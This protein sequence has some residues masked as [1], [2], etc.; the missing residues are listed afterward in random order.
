MAK[1]LPPRIK[2]ITGNRYGRWTVVGFSHTHNK[3]SYWN[4]RCDCGT[5]RTHQRSA[6]ISGSTYSCGCFRGELLTVRNTTHGRR[7]SPEYGSWR[8][9]KERCQNP[10]SSKFYLYGG[11][12]IA[13][14]DRWQRFDNFFADMGPKPTP[15]HTLE[16]IDTNGNYEPDNCRWIPGA[17]QAANRRNNHR[18]T[19]GEDTRTIAE[20]RR[21]FHISK[22]TY[23]ARIHLG[24][25]IES[26]LTTPVRR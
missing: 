6:L 25:S 20:W 3:A 7:H 10:R 5:L 19:I 4:C 26:A 14:C 13:I 22:S 16:R 8:A 12:G 11:R 1:R 15:D 21:H 2:D 9:M 23:D 17:E 24:W 18:V